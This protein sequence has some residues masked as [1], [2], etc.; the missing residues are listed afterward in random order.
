MQLFYLSAIFTTTHSK[1]KVSSYHQTH[2]DIS[3][4]TLSHRNEEYH[5]STV[6]SM[7][8]SYCQ[9]DYYHG[10]HDSKP[11]SAYRQCSG[12]ITNSSATPSHRNTRIF[13]PADF[14]RARREVPS[15]TTMPSWF[16]HSRVTD[17]K[18]Y[19]AHAAHVSMWQEVH[20]IRVQSGV[21]AQERYV[22]RDGAREQYMAAY[23]GARQAR[24]RRIGLDTVKE[25]EQMW[26]FGRKDT[27]CNK[28]EKLTDKK[29]RLYI[30]RRK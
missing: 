26:W 20:G 17:A 5:L 3:Y 19:A 30:V 22:D 4:N 10:D 16:K 29:D 7:P 14:T 6:L 21:W 28:Q 9:N 12:A 27:W 23:S 18:S 24:R 1:R 15:E 8:H 11:T 25:E 13:E 2:P